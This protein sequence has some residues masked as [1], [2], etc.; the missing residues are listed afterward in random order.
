M[1]CMAAPELAQ[2]MLCWML[3]SAVDV[4]NS[5]KCIGCR[6]DPGNCIEIIMYYGVNI[7]G[8]EM[9]HNSFS[10]SRSRDTLCIM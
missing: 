10:V 5:K 8:Y 2:P 1:G 3:A 9:K 7:V 6:F 4:N